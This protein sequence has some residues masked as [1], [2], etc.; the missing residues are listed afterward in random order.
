M[1]IRVDLGFEEADAVA[2][3]MSQ[4]ACGCDAIS[5][6]ERSSSFSWELHAVLRHSVAS[7]LESIDSVDVGWHSD[8]TSDVS[9]NGNWHTIRRNKSSIST[10]ASAT[11]SLGVVNIQSSS[12]NHIGRMDRKTASRN[13]SS[14]EWDASSTFKDSDC[15]SRLLLYF[16]AVG[17]SKHGHVSFL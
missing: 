1:R 3:G 12:P 9:S 11:R 4:W 16:V 10:T 13:I 8:A 15:S 17:K 5:L 14:D 6:G 2:Y 7:G